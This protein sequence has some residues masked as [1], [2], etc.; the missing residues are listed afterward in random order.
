MIAAPFQPA[1]VRRHS[2]KLVP[3]PY[4]ESLLALYRFDAWPEGNSS[5]LRNHANE[6]E[7]DVSSGGAW[8]QAINYSPFWETGAVVGTVTTDIILKARAAGTVAC[9]NYQKVDGVVWSDA[10]FGGN[11]PSV[12]FSGANG[13]GLFSFQ[14]RKTGAVI[15]TVDVASSLA[16]VPHFTAA[17]WGDAP[18]MAYANGNFAVGT[19]TGATASDVGDTLCLGCNKTT[20]PAGFSSWLAAW[21]EQLPVEA[22][23]YL[24]NQMAPLLART[25]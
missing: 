13:T 14:H 4:A 12:D 5:T 8:N 23:H 9:I 1:H 6:T 20:R 19:Q 15:E 7:L 18:I 2:P 10:D 24:Y 17:S 3:L 16:S 21:S 11:L 25:P 22:L